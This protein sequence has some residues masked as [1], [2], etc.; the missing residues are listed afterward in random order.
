MKNLNALP[1]SMALHSSAGRA[2]TAIMRT[3]TAR[4][5]TGYTS[6]SI[7]LA[8]TSLS[9][10]PEGKYTATIYTLIKEGRFQ[11]VIKILS[12]E[13]HSFPK[14]RAALSLLGYCYYQVHDFTSASEMY[15]RLV[16]LCPEVEEYKLYYA[17]SLAK[18]GQ[19][20]PALKACGAVEHPN[21]AKK[22]P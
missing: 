12:N 11:D 21:M 15:E 14:N 10:I 19:Q 6:I 18:S 8:P 7:G 20:V 1:M 4:P 13:L 17:Q 22:V 16:M 2:A 5:T 3:A 9:Q